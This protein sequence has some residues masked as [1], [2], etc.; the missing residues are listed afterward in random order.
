MAGGRTEDSG[1]RTEWD[2]AH[3]H[4]ASR[5]DNPVLPNTTLLDQITQPSALSPQSS[6]LI[7]V[8]G[9]VQGVG[10]RP[11]V[12][13]LAL[14][15]GL[16]GWVL[17]DGE[18]VEIAVSGTAEAIQALL[19][20][21]EQE[22]PPL[23]RIDSIES[24]S[25]HSALP[26]GFTILASRG[27]AANT[28]VTPDAA[29]CPDCLAELFDPADRRY[30]Y[31]FIN[32][33][34]CGPR[35]TITAHLPYDR[36]NTSMAGFTLC[37]A[38][39][40]EYQDPLDRRFHAQPNACPVCGPRLDLVPVNATHV[41][42]N[43]PIAAALTLLRTGQILA[44][45]GLGG[46]HLMCDARNGTAVAELRRRKQREAKPF[47]VLAANLASLAG[48]AKWG[49]GEATLLHSRERPIVL[50]E[51]T[52]ACDT[53]LPGVAEG[54]AWLGA[55]L[56]YTPLQWLL[57]HE[58]AGRPAGTAW[59]D[60]PQE[61]LLVCTS[62]NPGGEPLVI[63]NDE[64]L[65]RLA[66]IADA[67]L[68]HDREILVGCD[69]SVVR[70][71][72]EW[73]MSD[74]E[75]VKP[76]THH[77]SPITRNFI[78]RARGYT[79]RAI[80]LPHAGPAVLASGGW[81][82]NTV[83]LTRGDEA[84]LSQHIGDL[85]NAATCRAMEDAVFHLM[86]VLEIVPEAVAS[87]RHPDF[88]SSRFAASF[89]TARGLPW[90]AV[91]HHHAHLAAV[92]A[93]HGETRP[94]LGLALDGVGLGDDGSAWGGELLR[95]EGAGY[96]RLGHLQALALPGGDRAAREPWRMGASALYALGRGGEI[97]NRYADQPAAALL[98]Q[99]LERDLNSPA[100]SSCGRLFD[101]AVGLLGI[102]PVMGFEGQ[103]AMLLESL[104]ARHGPVAPLRG[105]YVI[106]SAGTLNFL[107]LLAVLAETPDAA[108]GAA[109]FHATL[110]AGLTEWAT[111]IAREQGV[112][113]IALSGG[114]FLN[115]ILSRELGRRLRENGLQV[116]EAC[117][118]PPNDG[119]LSLGQAWLAVLEG[120]V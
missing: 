2:V 98:T 14:E 39:R 13:R 101:A 104:A 27:G 58:A 31:P 37:P 52:S 66:G 40:A 68:L 95:L 94:T 111:G 36:P 45:K 91:Q 8:R 12:Y 84:F 15:L 75:C 30:R 43:D 119:G 65:A 90:H 88:H 32:C 23:A 1:L 57:L 50:L 25:V 73:V 28:A 107:P 114:C 86:D 92:L 9:T 85:D 106:E 56:P 81:F 48:L 117:Q 77:P 11:F 22:A 96:T 71:N 74:E 67:F 116:L 80:K 6:T 54:V 63:A 44:V 35:Y 118:A 26:P 70:A 38:C 93:E 46:F 17:N 113:R 55:L 60:T 100:T 78:R 99:M 103:A 87:D 3:A 42:E 110:A 51:K 4:I 29:T 82:K 76:I 105:G 64:A 59:L 16:N 19:A 34:H 69:D 10:F 47:A 7:R 89:A 5:S 61:L 97:A 79:P 120:S 33:T 62:A 115:A 20:R 24:Q 53:A 72:R 49:E 21:L 83:C 18:G 112:D 108:R 102:M 41:A 109:L